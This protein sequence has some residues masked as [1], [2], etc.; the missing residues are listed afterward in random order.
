MRM[1]EQNNKRQ[2][3]HS[4]KVRHLSVSSWHIRISHFALLG[5]FKLLEVLEKYTQNLNEEH[6]RGF[7]SIQMKCLLSLPQLYLLFLL[8]FESPLF[9]HA[10]EET[11]QVI[12]QSLPTCCFPDVKDFNSQNS[13]WAWEV[14]HMDKIRLRD[15]VPKNSFIYLSFL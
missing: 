5:C 3:L 4:K 12:Q 11:V 15:T 1:K 9:K 7:Q 13:Q 6:W 14:Q 8:L 10:F 2:C